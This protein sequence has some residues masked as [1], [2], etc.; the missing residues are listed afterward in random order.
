MTKLTTKQLYG[1]SIIKWNN[2]Q[3][4]FN[5]INELIYSQCSFCLDSKE[6]H[7]CRINPNICNCILFKNNSLIST[8]FNNVCL[9]FSKT[10]SKI[11]LL[12]IELNN[13]Y[14][15]YIQK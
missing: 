13:K 2:I 7:N 14:N 5:E 8:N 10:Y 1:Y 12:I 9:A 11:N 3:Q 4:N 15:E 6:L